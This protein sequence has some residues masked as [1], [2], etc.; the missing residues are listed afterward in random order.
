MK[1]RLF[2]YTKNINSYLLFKTNSSI[3]N[4][5]YIAV[6]MNLVYLNHWLLMN[7]IRK[8]FGII[9]GFYYTRIIRN[10]LM[11]LIQYNHIFLFNKNYNRSIHNELIRNCRTIHF[12]MKYQ[13]FIG[14]LEDLIKE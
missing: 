8:E 7:S 9:K 1:G 6:R 4:L 12:K 3:T 2:E 14:G 13:E 5:D 10:N 11:E